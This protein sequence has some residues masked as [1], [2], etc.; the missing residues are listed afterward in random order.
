MI[1]VC[2]YSNTIWRVYNGQID[3][4]GCI[5]LLEG[6]FLKYD[7][8]HPEVIRFIKETNVY[9]EQNC[10]VLENMEWSKHTIA[11]IKVYDDFI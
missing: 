4:L 10:I 3:F 5:F 1:E 6:Q 9:R 2:P 7:K 8:D 11:T